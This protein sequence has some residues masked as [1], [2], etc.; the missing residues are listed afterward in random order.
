M[1]VLLL[2]QRKLIGLR[3][4]MLNL[5][6]GPGDTSE[7]SS[8]SPKHQWPR[9]CFASHS[10]SISALVLFAREEL[11][12][13]P[14]WDVFGGLFCLWKRR[15][16]RIKHVFYFYVYKI[17]TGLPAILHLCRLW[18]LGD[19]IVCILETCYKPPWA[20]II[21]NYILKITTFSALLFSEL[22]TEWKFFLWIETRKGGGAIF[23]HR[24]KHMHPK[25]SGR[26]ARARER[27]LS[28]VSSA[29]LGWVC[30]EKGRTVQDGIAHPVSKPRQS[31]RMPSYVRHQMP[32]S[33]LPSIWLWGSTSRAYSEPRREVMVCFFFFFPKGGQFF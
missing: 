2:Q 1:L 33:S 18:A 32:I 14:S 26:G 29:A 10:S 30:D 22:L 16:G 12:Y 19:K 4:L 23:L 20:Q 5:P 27:R 3:E 7:T 17:C 13:W 15:G 21:C 9:F 11:L 31:C 28:Q 8:S 24:K 6:S 25:D